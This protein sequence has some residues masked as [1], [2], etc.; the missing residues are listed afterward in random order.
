[1]SSLKKATISSLFWKILERGFYQAVQLV[2]QVILARLL[3]PG[4]FGA[5]AIML[6]FINIGNVITQS[7]LNTALVQF[8]E[9]EKGD[10]STAFWLSFLLSL[11]IYSIVF[12]V[13]PDVAF[14]YSMVE[15]VC[16]LRILALILPLGAFNSI[17]IAIIQRRLELRKTF[18]AT[19]SAVVTSG[20]VGVGFAVAG[21]GLWALV[22]Q[23]VVYQFV[24]CVVLAFEVKWIPKLAFSMTRAKLLFSYGWKLLVSGLLDQ[25][26]Q[27]LSDLVI[28]RQF[29]AMSL[30]LVSQ[31]KKYPQAIGTMLDGS[32]QPVMLSAVSRVQS[33]GASVKRLIRRALKTS[34]FFIAPA[35]TL[36]SCCAPSLVPAL[37]GSKWVEA[38]P[39]MQ[40]YCMV[41]A[42][43]PIHTTN[44]QA[45]NGMG[46]SDLFLRLE[47]VKKAYGVAALLFCAFVLD[48]VGALVASYL[49]TG[50]VST[51]VNAWPNKHV[52][53]YS[54]IEQVHDIAPAFLLSGVAAAAASLVSAIGFGP[55]ATVIIQIVL[56]AVV[57]LGFAAA[58]RLE[59]F[60]YLLRTVHSIFS[61]RL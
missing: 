5:L 31:G 47:L 34:T 26:Y 58:L 15:I 52:I 11:I 35:M 57:Y 61:S 13:A 39:F 56:F 12:I 16:P 38:V 30:G 1:M 49:A 8:P 44:L 18:K 32:I 42:L 46:R 54:Y 6:V 45:L 20:F 7:G 28:G 17:Q 43:M 2:V 53:N 37:L 29:S 10:C 4:D 25:G 36:F 9:L 22:A 33:D 23:Q 21:A 27:S 60:T 59:A 3:A 19:V 41:Y 50:V 55:W 40:V 14:Y 48:D 51:F 24:G